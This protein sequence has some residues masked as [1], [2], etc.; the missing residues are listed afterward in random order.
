MKDISGIGITLILLGVIGF[1]VGR[2]SYTDKEKVIDMGPIQATAEKTH[3]LPISDIAEALAVIA[4]VVLVVVA[5]GKP[6]P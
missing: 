1:A 6:R 3:S 2:I 4:G 5:P